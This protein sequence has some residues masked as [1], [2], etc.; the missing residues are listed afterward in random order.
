MGGTNVGTAD[1]CIMMGLQIARLSEQTTEKLTRVLPAFGTAVGNPVDV[2]V[3]MLM[4]PQIY[5]DVIK[6]LAGDES[7]DMLLA[8]TA[9]ESPLS[10]K[11]IADAA[12]EIPKPLAVALFDIR[13]FVEQQ[14][15][16]LLN[17]HIPAYTEAKRAAMAL[18]KMADYAER[19]A[20]V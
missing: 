10:V 15:Q 5:G 1:N 8:V 12:K 9:P 14:M 16:L 4:P 11:R 3:G 6:I 7:V 13:G 2:G 17:Q 20:R 19:R 18:F